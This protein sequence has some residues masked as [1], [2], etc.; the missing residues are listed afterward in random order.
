MTNREAINAMSNIEMAD[1]LSTIVEATENPCDLCPAELEC[2]RR[3]MAAKEEGRELFDSCYQIIRDW[4]D[5]EEEH[6]L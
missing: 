6:E 1:W 3:R 2:R 4:L 5:K